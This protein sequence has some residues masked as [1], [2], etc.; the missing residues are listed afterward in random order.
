MAEAIVVNLEVPGEGLK[1]YKVIQ[2]FSLE[3]AG[4]QYCALTETEERE[5][6]NIIFL[7]CSIEPAS[8]GEDDEQIMTVELIPTEDEYERVSS[9]Y[10]EWLNETVKL[11]LRQ[12]FKNES[13]FFVVQDKDGN[14]VSFIAHAIFD[15]ETNG[16]SYI[17]VQQMLNDGS[18][19]EEISFY[20]FVEGEPCNIDMIRSDME[21]GRVKDLFLKLAT[22][23]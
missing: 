8:D 18:I 21:Y 22:T 15:D 4:R 9:S 1:A 17:A 11:D 7:R 13:D 2:V 10:L 19:F 23:S 16:R 5:N 12:T 14:E 20:R 3:G 6:Q